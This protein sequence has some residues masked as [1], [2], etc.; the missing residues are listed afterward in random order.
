MQLEEVSFSGGLMTFC[1]GLSLHKRGHQLWFD[2]P[3]P[4]SLLPT[5]S[6]SSSF[7]SRHL[8]SLVQVTSLQVHCAYLSVV[9]LFLSVCFCH[10]LGLC[11]PYGSPQSIPYRSYIHI[12]MLGRGLSCGGLTAANSGEDKVNWEPRPSSK[13]QIVWTVPS[14]C[15]SAG[16]IGM[17]NFSQ[18]RWPVGFFVFS[19]LPNY[20]H[21]CLAW[22]L[23]QP[24]SLGVVG[25]GLQLFDAKDLAQFLNYITREAST[26]IALEPGQGPKDRD[27]TSI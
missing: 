11:L 5:Y 17:G 18:M 9:V 16:I 12:H 26:Y 25:H 20:V 23:Y 4:K 10:Q 14:N 15:G 22:Y 24:V 13:H 21:N 19:Q 27:V 1:V 7:P 6:W 2:A 8:P 3:P